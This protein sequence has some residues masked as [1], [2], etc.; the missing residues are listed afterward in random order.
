MPTVNN[1]LPMAAKQQPAGLVEYDSNG[2][3]IKLSM[4]TV[5]NYLVSGSGNV[6]DQECVMFMTLCKYQHLNPFLREAYLIKYGNSPAT[7][8][9]GKDVFTKRAKRNPSYAGKQAGIIVQAQDGT[10]E[11]RE[12]TFRLPTETIVGGWAKVF[13][14]G[15]EVPEYAAV[16]FNEYAGRKSDGSLNG[17]WSSK[18]ATMIRKVALVQA[19][20]EAFPEDFQGLYSPEEIPA[21]TAADLPETAITPE[22]APAP[23]ETP[24]KAMNA[25]QADILP[26]ANEN[27]VETPESALFG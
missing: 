17:Q 24:E 3:K 27:P 5:R 21:A 13:I 9:T 4:Q 25:P 15:Q 23:L 10:V 19:L 16:S 22:G 26:T 11:E 2:E 1:K 6:S 12:G 20:R 7:I 14:K 8:V 18:P